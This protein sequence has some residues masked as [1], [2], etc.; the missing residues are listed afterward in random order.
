MS[1]SGQNRKT[2]T[3]AYVF[4]CSFNNGHASAEI[5]WDR[6]AFALHW[7]PKIRIAAPISPFT[8]RR[9]RRNGAARDGWWAANN[10]RR[11]QWHFVVYLPGRQHQCTG[12]DVRCIV[13]SARAVIDFVFSERGRFVFTSRSPCPMV[14]SSSS[15]AMLATTSSRS[16]KQSTKGPNGCSQLKC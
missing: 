4:R 9:L 7:P 1:E 14:A 6:L 16:R 2:S 5:K 8:P 13:M 11:D 3:R 15:C 10:D 12:H